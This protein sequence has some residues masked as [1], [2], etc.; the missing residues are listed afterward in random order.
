M[1]NHGCG[2]GAGEAGTLRTDG[3][4]AG[5]LLSNPGQGELMN[6]DHFERHW[7]TFPQDNT[8]PSTYAQAKSSA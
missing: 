7:K 5:D 6:R 1:R 8:S 3:T 2:G 4:T